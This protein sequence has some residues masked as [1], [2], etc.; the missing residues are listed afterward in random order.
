MVEF[1]RQKGHIVSVTG[2][3]TNDV[4]TL[5]EVDIGLS[6]GIHGTE[7]AKESSDIVILDDNFTSVAKVLMWG[8]CVSKNIQKFIQFQL[9]ANV[10][11]VTVNSVAIILEGKVPLKGVQLLWANIIMHTLGAQAF[12]TEQPSKELMENPPVGW[13]Q[14][15]YYQKYVEKC[16]SPSFLSDWSPLDL[17]NQR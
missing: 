10:V 9:T 4:P 17:A 3:G 2:D 16:L 5:K 7:V 1:L 15:T 14:T 12:A 6:M 8:R 13:T 11:A